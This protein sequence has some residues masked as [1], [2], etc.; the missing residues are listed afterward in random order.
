[1]RRQLSGLFG[2]SPSRPA[3]NLPVGQ[4]RLELG[5]RDHP[6]AGDLLEAKVQVGILK[7]VLLDPAAKH[8]AHQLGGGTGGIV[9]QNGHLPLP[10][11]GMGGPHDELAP[12]WIDRPFLVEVTELVTLPIRRVVAH[13]LDH[14]LAADLALLPKP[15]PIALFPSHQVHG[16]LGQ[17]SLEGLFAEHRAINDDRDHFV[18]RPTQRRPCPVQQSPEPLPQILVVVDAFKV[19]RLTAHGVEE[20]AVQRLVGPAN[21]RA[22]TFEYLGH[23]GVLLGMRIQVKIPL[24]LG[25]DLLTV[26]AQEPVGGR[27]FG[28][29]LEPPPLRPQ[30]AQLRTEQE[31]QVV[32]VQ[33]LGL[34]DVKRTG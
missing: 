6:V 15:R 12:A 29:F 33:K 8:Q 1:M 11:G 7:I 2:Q 27:S 31:L 9:R 23:A 5:I 3:L 13:A 19:D 18:R 28:Q 21:R 10:P 4:L 20:I 24:R 14:A 25:P 26:P 17:N 22:P 34:F 16:R 30:P 32:R